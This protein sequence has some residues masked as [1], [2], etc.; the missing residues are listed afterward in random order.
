MHF[1]PE[2]GP[3]WIYLNTKA[4]PHSAR[5]VLGC[6]TTWELKLLLAWVK[7][8]MLIGCELTFWASLVE[9]CQADI[10]LRYGVSKAL[11]DG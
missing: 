3:C 10:C 6:E 5:T 8:S 7:I 9:G 11:L 1:K 2:A 4:K